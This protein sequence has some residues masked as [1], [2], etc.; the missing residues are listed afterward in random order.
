M[1]EHIA[2]GL[3]K[4]LVEWSTKVPLE[5]LVAVYQQGFEDGYGAPSMQATA[6]KPKR[7]YT[8]RK[9]SKPV[10]KPGRVTINSGPTLKARLTEYMKAHDINK[11]Y[12]YVEV[13]KAYPELPCWET[14]KRNM[15]GGIGKNIHPNTIKAL[16]SVTGVAFEW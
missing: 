6:P 3:A 15:V 14:M 2:Q 12:Q 7:K 4:V 10:A 1:K 5:A 16:E 8:R 11:R 13:R 9:T